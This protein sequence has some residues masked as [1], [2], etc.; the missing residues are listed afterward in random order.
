[1]VSA[2]DSVALVTAIRE[3]RNEDADQIGM[4]ARNYANL[5]WSSARV[6]GDLERSLEAAA[7]RSVH[8][9]V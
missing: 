9:V 3:L 6:L 8:S 4:N 7:R 1:V 2:E 5:R